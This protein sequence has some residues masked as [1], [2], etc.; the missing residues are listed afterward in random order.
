[1]ADISLSPY[2]NFHKTY[3]HQMWQAGTSRGADLNETNQVVGGDAITSRLRDKLKA[4]YLYHQSVFG[5]QN[6]QDGN[7]SW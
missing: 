5:D 1:M 4:W 2:L 6:G 7:L 3:D